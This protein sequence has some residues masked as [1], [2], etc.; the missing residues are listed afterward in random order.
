MAIPYFPIIVCGIPD[1]VENATQLA[2]FPHNPPPFNLMVVRT[3][4]ICY[5][6]P[7]IT[8]HPFDTP[9]FGG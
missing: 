3:R 6:Y 2:Y 8:L 4:D 5:K 9:N 1:S 7:N